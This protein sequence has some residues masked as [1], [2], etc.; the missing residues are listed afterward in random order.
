MNKL[1]VKLRLPVTSSA[2]AGVELPIPTKD[3]KVRLPSLPVVAVRVFAKDA[4][5][6]L[7]NVP[8]ILP[9]VNV[10]AVPAATGANT[11]WLLTNCGLVTV[12]VKNTS[13]GNVAPS[14]LI[15]NS[16]GLRLVHTISLNL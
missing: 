7:Q 16:P 8:E 3:P 15:E 1:P 9:T 2:K 4:F 5:V 12:P 13:P 6:M 11:I 10:D 14:K